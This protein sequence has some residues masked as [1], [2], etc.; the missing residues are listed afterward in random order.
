MLSEIWNSYGLEGDDKSCRWLL[1]LGYWCDWDQQKEPKQPQISWSWVST[2]S[3]SSV[4]WNPVLVFGELPDISDEDFYSVPEDDEEEV[5]L[6]NDVPHP[7]SQKLNDLVPDLSLSTS[8][9]KLLASRLKEKSLLSDSAH[10]I[11]YHNRH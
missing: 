11:F 5:V 2:S 3:C 6:N 10:I 9:V 4:W 7:F 8:S 1:L